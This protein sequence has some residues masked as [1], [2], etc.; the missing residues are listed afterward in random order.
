MIY[1]GATGGVFSV[2]Q[3]LGA[4]IAVSPLATLAGSG[5]AAAG[6]WFRAGRREEEDP[7][8]EEEPAAEEP[9]AEEPAAEKT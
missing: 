5:L 7:A 9:A 3:A 2:F 8:T 1:G 6:A 4:T